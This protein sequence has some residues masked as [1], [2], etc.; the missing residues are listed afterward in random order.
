[1]QVAKGCMHR[2]PRGEGVTSHLV[3]DDQTTYSLKPHWTDP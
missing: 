2:G 1:M 3:A